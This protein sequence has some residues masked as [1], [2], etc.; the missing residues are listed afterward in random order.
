VELT[1]GCF[2][3]GSPGEFFD[4]TLN[5]MKTVI[6]P[7]FQIPKLNMTKILDIMSETYDFKYIIL[8]WQGDS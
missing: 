2:S 3:S 4:N 8:E 6:L 1:C 5:W 7:K